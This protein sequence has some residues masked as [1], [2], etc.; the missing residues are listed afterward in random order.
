MVREVLQTKSFFQ[1]Y[2]EAARSK[3]EDTVDEFIAHIK[4]EVFI[5][6]KLLTVMRSIFLEKNAKK[7]HHFSGKRT[8]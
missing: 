4:S 1:R 7:K 2:R 3:K 6:Q 5:S 8:P